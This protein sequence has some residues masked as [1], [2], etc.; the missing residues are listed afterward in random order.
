MWG[1]W[2]LK[3]HVAVGDIMSDEVGDVSEL[4]T[5]CVCVLLI[6]STMYLAQ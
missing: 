5:L 1:V 4:T 3:E 2:G 6:W